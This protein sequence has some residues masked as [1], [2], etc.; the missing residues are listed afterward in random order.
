MFNIINVTYKSTNNINE[1]KQFLSEIDNYSIFAAD[2]E[3][4]SAY[5]DEDRELC[6]KVVN[7][8]TCTKDDRIKAQAI[9]KSDALSHPHHTVLTHCSI[10][11]SE[12]EGYV[13]I[14]DTDEITQLVLQY[15]VTTNITQVWHN[16]SFDFRYLQYYTNKLPLV[17][18]DSQQLAK[19]LV[20]HV[21]T[22]KARTGLK[23][24]AGHWYGDW[25]ISKD[26]FK[27]SQMYEPKMLLYAA[28]DSCA[29]LKLWKYLQEQ[30]NILDKELIEENA[31]EPPEWM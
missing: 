6:K 5:S 19:T 4:A 9:L 18:E 17:Y 14:L 29:T 7:D 2:F 28:I 13:F 31:N 12:S 22:S 23:L 16:A 10:G 8:N 20:N 21:D 3:T 25:G 11:I 30:C 27:L 15:L 1:A 24:L 26:L